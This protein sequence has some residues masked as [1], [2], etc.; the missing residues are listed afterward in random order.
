MMNI[1]PTAF[2]GSTLSPPLFH[3]AEIP[4]SWFSVGSAY[5]SN[6]TRPGRSD[7]KL[8]AESTTEER[9]QPSSA[10]VNP[11]FLFPEVFQF[12]HRC[13]VTRLTT[14]ITRNFVMHNFSVVTSVEQPDSVVVSSDL[15]DSSS[16]QRARFWV[17]ELQNCEEVRELQ[18]YDRRLENWPLFKGSLTDTD[19]AF[20]WQH[21]WLVLIV[22]VKK[23]RRTAVKVSC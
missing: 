15:T 8:W 2:L 21:Q 22:I 17:K 11:H 6:R 3:P 18:T 5:I 7:T 4:G 12:I 13:S 9:E 19:T 10:T 23:G 1:F 14:T 20:L 16:F